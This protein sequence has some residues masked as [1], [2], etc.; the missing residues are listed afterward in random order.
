MK[1]QET[2]DTKQKFLFELHNIIKE[3][4]KIG[5][6]ISNPPQNAI[7]EEFNLTDA[8]LS[9]L[10]AQPFTPESISAIEK[11]VRDTMMNAFFEAFC[12]VDGVG[13]PHESL[14]EQE[15]VWLGLKLT[16]VTTNE[17]EVEVSEFLHDEFFSTYQD[18]K[19]WQN[20]K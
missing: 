16:E 10:K 14:L 8:E 1:E 13:D 20:K 18:W 6:R 2:M 3:R 19:E 11:I 15:E 17:E 7:W 5:N 12:I 4:S 9:A